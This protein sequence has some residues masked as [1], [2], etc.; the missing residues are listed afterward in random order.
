MIYELRSYR[1]RPGTAP[2]YLGLLQ[3]EGL[4]LVTRHLPLLGYWM[5]ETGRLNTLHH[6]W[7]YRDWAHRAACRAGLAG[8]TAWTQ[9]FIPRAFAMVEAQEN[10]LLTLVH[11]SLPLQAAIDAAAREHPAGQG[12]LFADDCAAL[13]W[14][15]TPPEPGD[16]LAVWR[17]LS[18]EAGAVRLGPRAADPVPPA[19]PDGLRHEIVRPLSFSP[20]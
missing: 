7:L 13:S 16:A 11:G 20:L 6:L 9:G 19:A 15:A 2:A 18:G 1:L 10:A 8:E 14:H 12:T 3:Q 4:P 17:S 5:T